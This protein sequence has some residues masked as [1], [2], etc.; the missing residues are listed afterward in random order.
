MQCRSHSKLLRR[1]PERGD[2]FARQQ[3][4]TELNI[5]VISNTGI[6]D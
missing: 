2:G 5:M 6:E 1:F 3:N 4:K